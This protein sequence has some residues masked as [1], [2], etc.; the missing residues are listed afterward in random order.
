MTSDT[1]AFFQPFGFAGG[2]YNQPSKLV[3]FGARDYD[4]R[5]A[6][7]WTTKDSILFNGG[8]TNLYGYVLGDP[9]NFT[10]PT[11][12]GPISAGW[13]C[14]ALEAVDGAYGF[15][16]AIKQISDLTNEYKSKLD[17]NN[18]SA[19]TRLFCRLNALG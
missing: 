13:I 4:P 2:L 9:I 5:A 17:A 14:A 18:V 1:N 7:R 12:K 6:G 10:D 15:Y 16:T 11:G 19:P 3:R 8:D